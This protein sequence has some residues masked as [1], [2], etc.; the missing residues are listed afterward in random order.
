[1][2]D[3]IGIDKLLIKLE[4]NALTEKGRLASDYGSPQK[5]IEYYEQ[6]E[7][8]EIKDN[9]DDFELEKFEQISKI[10]NR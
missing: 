7:N 10:L 8:N 4:Y 1:M 2:D 3:E 5:I 6:E 9:F